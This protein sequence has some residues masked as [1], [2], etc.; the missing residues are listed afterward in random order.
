MDNIVTVDALVEQLAL[1]NKIETIKR[2][3]TVDL[4]RKTKRERLEARF[5]KL[6]I[7]SEAVNPL[8]EKEA[9]QWVESFL[10]DYTIIEVVG[11]LG[12]RASL[13]YKQKDKYL[14]EIIR[15]FNT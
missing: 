7:P 1:G 13:P 3:I 9:R 6:L 4:P 12:K 15:I 2:T 8:Y 5:K 11:Q 14:P 10:D